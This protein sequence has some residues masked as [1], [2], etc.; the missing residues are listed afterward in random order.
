MK[1]LGHVPKKRKR[2]APK[3]DRP[4]QTATAIVTGD[5][6][7]DLPLGT[8][9]NTRS[10]QFRSLD[11]TDVSQGVK[12]WDSFKGALLALGLTG[13]DHTRIVGT[14]VCIA[15]G[16]AVTA[17]HVLRESINELLAGEV[18]P[19]CMGP[20]NGELDLWKVT[21]F[22]HAESDDIT[23]LSL[24]LQSAITP[25]WH[26]TSFKIR[27]RPPQVGEYLS[28]VGFRF[29]K[30]VLRT[31]SGGNAGDFVGKLLA[32][33]GPVEDFFPISR[34]PSLMNYPC[35]Q[36]G[37]GS[38]GGVSG[39][40]VLDDEGSLVG[41]LSRSYETAEGSGPSM[42]SWLIPTLGREI[43]PDWPPGLYF[44]KQRVIDIRR[45]LL[46]LVE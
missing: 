12:D 41:I 24:Q 18:A 36:I 39:G 25:S 15:P 28:I 21:Q 33:R 30:K 42:A 40:A 43:R 22:V 32:S 9:I 10:E 5:P 44:E 27:T 20:R 45:D 11:A 35:I 13:K 8:E 2:Q 3:G 23:Y 4:R 6:L 26:M 1:E 16:L 19:M 17:S 7:A 38:P 14:A 29:P 37:C 31:S 34:D 46:N